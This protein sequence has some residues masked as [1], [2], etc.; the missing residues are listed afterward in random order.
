[1]RLA[2]SALLLGAAS[3]A[4]A[5]DQVVL[6]GS[7]SAKPKPASA[8]DVVQESI[9]GAG[10]QARAL[11]DEISLLAPDAV[12]AF[13]KEALGRK[14]KPANRRPDS[15][16]DHVVRGAEIN[17]LWA[18]ESAGKA[19]DSEDLGSYD[20]RAKK[21]D[22]ARLGID[23]VKQYSGY[24]DDNENDKHLFY[25]E[26]YTLRDRLLPLVQRKD[27]NRRRVLRVAE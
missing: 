16:W 14:P 7:G 15:E 22:P 26:S 21:V 2:T 20:L 13:E 9:A 8:W 4:L 25:C 17:Q 10:D 11:W 18:A 19:K 12:A 27:A 23:D 1:M 24:L 3:S 5:L 6:G